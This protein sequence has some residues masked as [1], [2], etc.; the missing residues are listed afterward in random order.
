MSWTILYTP[1]AARSLRRLDPA[2]R[3]KIRR[4]LDLL[5]SDPSRGKPLH[6]N[7]KGLRSWRTGDFRIVYRIVADR[8]E[9]FI[10]ALGHRRDVYER[11]RRKLE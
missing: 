6:L 1:S 7:M 9:I 4:A 2:T 10:I 11:L 5:A 8:V 3:D